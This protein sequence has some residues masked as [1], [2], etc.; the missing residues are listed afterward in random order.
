MNPIRFEADYAEPRNRL[1]VFFRLIVAIPWSS[2]SPSTAS[3]AFLAAIVA[4]FAMLFTK[5]YP[6]GLY[7][8]VAGYVKLGAQIGGCV[9]AGRPTNGRPF[10]PDRDD[11][12]SGSRS[13]RS[14]SSIEGLTRSSSPAELPAAVD[15]VRASYIFQGAAFVAWWRILFTGKQSATMHD[16]TAD[17]ACLLGPGRRV[18]VA[19]DRDPS[20]AARPAAAAYPADAPSLP[21]P[22]QMP[23]NEAPLP[24]ETPP[25]DPPAPPPAPAA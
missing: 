12:R 6:Q 5:R 11:I 18:P 9:H 17:V 23:I 21:G 1:T 2:G 24:A 22:E 19:A 13:R 20:A 14:R 25:A 15:P 8:F 7:D 4:W 10:M 3:S 16:A